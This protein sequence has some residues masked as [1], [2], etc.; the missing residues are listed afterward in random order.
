[1][2]ADAADM[3]LQSDDVQREAL[4]RI[5]TRIRRDILRASD[6]IRRLRALLA[7]HEPER[8]DFNVGH[9]LAD[10]A[11][12]LRAEA[13]RRK[14]ALVVRS[15][16]TPCYIAGDRT[17]VQQVLINLLLNA[18]DAMKDLPEHRRRLEVKLQSRPK[19]VLI[20]VQDSGHGIAPENFAKLFESFFSTKQEGMGLGL[21]IARSIIEAHGGRIW[22]ENRESGG[23]VFFV[24]VSRGG[25]EN[26][27]PVG[28]SL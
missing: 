23:A 4:L 8:R 10:V 20:T 22:A 9:A 11:M 19:D 17:Q 7:R 1:M 15:T 5:V 12:I 26:P 2:S 18:M 24:E 6:V 16:D 13:E 14:V 3:L 28:N 21:S 27:P 25:P